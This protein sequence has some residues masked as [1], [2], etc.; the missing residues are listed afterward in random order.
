M[1]NPKKRYYIIGNASG[2]ILKVWDDSNPDVN[3]Y[4]IFD[5]KEEAEKVLS[6][7][8]DAMWHIEEL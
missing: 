4:C 1:L 5:T 2:I 7:V 6:Q 3:Y 8:G